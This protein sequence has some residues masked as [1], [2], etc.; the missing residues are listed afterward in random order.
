MKFN[1]TKG[2]VPHLAWGNPQYQYRL[3]YKHIES[4]PGAEMDFGV[5]VDERLNMTWQYMLGAQKDNCFPS[6]IKQVLANRSREGILPLCS[7]FVRSHLGYN[8]Q[9]V[10]QSPV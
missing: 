10:L 3:G 8:V 7:V 9:L 4:S 2:K 5:L 1:K 6:S